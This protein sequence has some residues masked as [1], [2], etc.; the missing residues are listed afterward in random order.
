MRAAVMTVQQ[1]SLERL[2]GAADTAHKPYQHFPALPQPPD[3]TEKYAYVDRNLP[4]LTVTLMISAACLIVSQ[5]RFE[6]HSPALWPFLAVTATYVIY[7][8][9]SLPVNFTGKGFDLA[10]H[11]ARVRAWHP[12]TYP[13]VDIYLPICG[14]PIG[15]LRN[16]WDAV[17]RLIAD[18]PGLAQAYVLDDGPC[19][20]ARS[21]SESLGFC[22]I[23]RPDLRAYKKSGN[24]R[25]RLRSHRRELPGYLRR[26][27]RAAPR[28]P[29]RDPP[30]HGRP[31]DRDRPD[32]PVLPGKR[33]ADVDRERGGLDPGGVLPGGPGSPRPV[34]RGHLRRDLRGL[35]AGRAGA[36]G[37]PDAD[38]VRRGRA[39]RARR[40][41]GRLVPGLPA[42]RAVDRHLPRQPRRVRAAAVP[43]VHRERWHR[44]LTPAVGHRR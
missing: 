27:L 42:D 20:E 12:D 44:L 21:V 7:Q 10:A 30:L 2:V 8:V 11:Q 38:P 32:A 33:R 31:G 14:E 34:R 25:L 39:H 22:Y 36:A 41:P 19:D 24:L 37:R 9:I 43:V 35:P 17:V 6:A 29:R 4:Y 3:D 16:T 15:M 26:G 13:S 18:Y 28:L 5:L 1:A 23:R 40:P